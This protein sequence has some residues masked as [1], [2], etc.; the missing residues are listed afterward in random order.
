LPLSGKS[1]HAAGK[2]GR[3]SLSA[4]ARLPLGERGDGLVRGA[5]KAARLDQRV[6]ALFET[7]R[8]SVTTP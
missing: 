6:F 4:A 7:T 1:C 8:F 2:N 3:M 5:G